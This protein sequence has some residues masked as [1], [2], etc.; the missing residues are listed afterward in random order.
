MATV[1][2]VAGDKEGN[3]EDARGGGMMVAMSHGL[4]VIFCLC[5]ETTKNNKVGPKKVMVSW[6]IDHAHLAIANTCSV[7]VV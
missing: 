7:S 2:R 4:C 6:S 3:S 5:G 1:T